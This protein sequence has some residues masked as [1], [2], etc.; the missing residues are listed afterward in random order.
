MYELFFFWDI[1]SYMGDFAVVG[2][3]ARQCTNIKFILQN[4]FYTCVIPQLFEGYVRLVI[5]EIL[6]E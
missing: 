5:A 2:F 6:V 1:P 4:P 3:V